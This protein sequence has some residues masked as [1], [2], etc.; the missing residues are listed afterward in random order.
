MTEILA[1]ISAL[2]YSNIAI[3]SPSL[4]ALYILILGGIIL[5]L[6]RTKLRHFG[7]LG[8]IWGILFWAIE[9]KPDIIISP[10]SDVVCFVEN[11]NFYTTSI[12]KG[13]RNSLSI[14]RNLGFDG[15]L[16]KRNFEKDFGKYENGLFVW[17]KK[18]YAKEISQSHHP[19]CPAYF[20]MVK[21]EKSCW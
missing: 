17:S 12:Q 15:K 3:K 2:P 9:E 6:L 1:V 11:G 14:Q 16:I 19:Y 21:S 8:I 18:G 20:K 5:C 13:K 4:T 7:W 10:E